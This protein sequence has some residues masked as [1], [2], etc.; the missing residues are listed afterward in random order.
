MEML[1]CPTAYKQVFHPEQHKGGLTPPGP[2]T[3]TPTPWAA[4][5]AAKPVLH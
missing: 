4:Q 2:T 3:S 1:G 5:G